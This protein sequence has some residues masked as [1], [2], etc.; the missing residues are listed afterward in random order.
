MKLLAY[1]SFETAL[2]MMTIIFAAELKDTPT[3]VNAANPG[4]TATD[5][6][7]HSG[8]R[9]VEQTA[10]VAARLVLL[11]ANGPTGEF[12]DENGSASW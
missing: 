8:H 6:N 3:K 9:T 12:F 11:P 4:Y 5:L 10:V 1:N 2:N 7:R